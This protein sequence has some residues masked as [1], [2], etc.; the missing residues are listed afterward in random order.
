VICF[1]LLNCY[2]NA[3]KVD[4][5]SNTTLLFFG[6]ETP[7]NTLFYPKHTNSCN[8]ASPDVAVQRYLLVLTSIQLFG[9]SL[10]QF[11]RKILSCRLASFP[12][13]KHIAMQSTALWSSIARSSELFK[14]KKG[15]LTL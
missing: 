13:T 8:M 15:A 12:N 10:P 2:K 9:Q 3:Q 7:L 6:S 5:F 1:L 4:A 11:I 14:F